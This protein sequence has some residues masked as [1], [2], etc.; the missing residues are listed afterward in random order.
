MATTIITLEDGLRIEAEETDT[1]VAIVDG[2]VQKTIDELKPILV[3]A[4]QPVV[5]AWQEL[6]QTMHIERAE[7]ELAFGF[8]ASGNLFLAS[9]KGNVNL[10]VKLT[11]TPS[12][13]AD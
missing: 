6:N 9:A 10:K 11:L 1:E 12:K 7:I 8:E 2:K 13:G 5:A 3:R 4:V